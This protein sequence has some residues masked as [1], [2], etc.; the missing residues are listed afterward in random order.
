MPSSNTPW[1]LGILL[2]VWIALAVAALGRPSAA[3]DYRF[4][5]TED[6]AIADATTGL[7]WRQGPDRATSWDGARQWVAALASADGRWRM[8][9]AAEMS[10]LHHFGDGMTHLADVFRNAGYWAW[11]TRDDGAP[12][13]WVYSFSYGGEGW[14]GQSPPD[15]GRVFAVRSPAR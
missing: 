7:V 6:G 5:Q 1:F 2:A 8:P 4:V 3:P 15:G 14:N 11:A 13:R 10:S 12:A 9:T